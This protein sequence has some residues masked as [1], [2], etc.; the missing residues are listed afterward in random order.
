MGESWIVSNLNAAL[1]TWNDK[2][3]EIWSLLTESPQTFKG[4]QVWGVMTGI[5]GA[6][7]AIGYGL[8]VLF[9]AVGV[10]KTCGS[11]VEVK[12]PEHALKL[13]I[14]FALA[15]GAV[16]YGLELMLAVFSIVQGM[17][18]TII[19]QSGSSGM[20]SVSLPQELI[21]AINNV[22][23]W[24]S[25]PLWAVTLIGGLLIT[26]LSFTM[27]LTVYGRMFS[28]W[29]YAAIA[30]IPLSTFA[31]EP[32]SSVGKNFIRSY[33][34]VCLQG[35]VIA[36]SCII[37][38]AISSSPPA[39]DTGAF[40]FP[41]AQMLGYR[42]G[43]DGQPEIIPEQAELIRMIYTSYLHGDSLQTIKSKV[44]AGG[45][46]TVRGNTTWSTQALLRILQNEKYCGDVLLQKTFTDNVLTG[47]PKKNTGQLPQY[48]IENNH[49][50][51]VTK[52]MYR[53]VQAEIARRNSK[54]CANRRKQKRGRYNSKYALSERLYC[55]ECGSPYKRVTWNIHGRKEIVWRCVNRVTYGTK[56][57]HNS[58]S[59]QE[60]A[61]HQTLLRAIQ[62][63]ADNYTE[64]VAMQINGILHDLQGGTTELEELQKK[65]ADARQEF[66]RLLDLSLECDASFLDEKLKH[67]SEE[68]DSLQKQI[69]QLTASQQKAANPN[70]QLTASDFHI[71]EYSD[72]IVARI[73]ERIDIVSANEI[74]IEFIG[75]YTVT[76]PLRS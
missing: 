8:L 29:M 51:I 28:L 19:T 75:G 23:F 50:G 61:L 47:G 43:A 67:T 24:D 37:F 70:L 34:G 12:K 4:G 27:I 16:T 9:F 71:T 56:F 35:V 57:C 68:I 49:E 60:E 1:S 20:S 13:F 48:Y 2:L 39:V 10:M 6:L 11:F 26:V 14:R 76:A 30:P 59:V 38:S 21:D 55:G 33:A 72:A 44:E 42:K 32:T 3:A 36:L 40:S 69:D 22:G 64:E 65:L 5:H 54:S 66:D 73:I 17:V 52:Q 31:G 7:Q 62:N 53:E 74:K 58:P 41:Y 46:K 15:K 45:Y 63:L 18:S 25:I